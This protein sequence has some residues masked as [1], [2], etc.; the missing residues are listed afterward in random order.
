[1]SKVYVGNL[2]W[3]INEDQLRSVFN[4]VGTVISASVILD[5]ETSRSRGFGFVEMS[6]DEEAKEAIEK[7]NGLEVEGRSIIVKEAL[8]ENKPR[9]QFTAGAGAS[10]GNILVIKC[11]NC[12]HEFEN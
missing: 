5:R 7:L 9:I 2:K 4:E 10:G 8:P 3:T 6:T 1:M 12:G 11:P